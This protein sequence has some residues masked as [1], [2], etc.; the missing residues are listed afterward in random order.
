MATKRTAT[1][2]LKPVETVEQATAD[3]ALETIEA[4]IQQV[5]DTF[6][7]SV[8]R[9]R[10]KGIRAL[11]YQALLESIEAG[12]L[13]ALTQRAIANAG[14]L[15]TG[16]TVTPPKRAPKPERKPR[17]TKTEAPAAKATPAAKKPRASKGSTVATEEGVVIAEQRHVDASAPVVHEVNPNKANGCTCGQS[18]G[19]KAA[20][21]RHINV[22]LKAAEA[23]A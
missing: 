5:V 21:S 11:A 9:A 4:A 12:D 6:G 14:S 19:S 10:L 17:A 22:M 7:V 13:E 16:W 15:P 3:E 8:Q 1:K 2:S 18:Y 20:L 23:Q